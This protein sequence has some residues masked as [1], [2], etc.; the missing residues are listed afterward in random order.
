MDVYGHVGGF[1]SGF[2]IAS[3]LMVGF[4]GAEALRSGSYET[5]CKYIGAGGL[6]FF[7]ILDSTLFATVSNVGRC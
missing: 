1:I 5:K 2:F 6:A 4:R 7:F 3:F